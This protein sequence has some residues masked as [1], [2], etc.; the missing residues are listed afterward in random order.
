[1]IQ[2]SLSLSY[3]DIIP[4]MRLHTSFSIVYQHITFCYILCCS[5][6]VTNFTVSYISELRQASRNGTGYINE[7]H[8]KIT[9]VCNFMM[10][11]CRN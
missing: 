3:I 10:L 8:G 9:F 7:P 5:F 2:V 1:M 6:R 4:I 11:V